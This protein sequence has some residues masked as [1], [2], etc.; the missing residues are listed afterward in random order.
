M[1]L[2]IAPVSDV[3]PPELWKIAQQL[4][5]KLNCSVC[6]MQQN[7]WS[8]CVIR[9]VYKCKIHHL[10]ATAKLD[11]SETRSW[12]RHTTVVL[13]RANVLEAVTC[14]VDVKFVLIP[15]PAMLVRIATKGGL[16]MDSGAIEPNTKTTLGLISGLS[17]WRDT[18]STT[19]QVKV[20][21]SPSQANR[22]PFS[23]TVEVSTTLPTTEIEQN[24]TINKCTWQCSL[25]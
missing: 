16:E 3:A 6:C 2:W 12:F 11:S 7:S 21:S 5:V 4:F 17:H 24:P 22:L 13:V 18:D 20:T 9:C 19:W 15:L 8:V 10:P 14:T 1:V 25:Y 23:S